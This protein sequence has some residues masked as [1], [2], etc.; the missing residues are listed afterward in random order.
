[1]N[2]MDYWRQR[3]ATWVSYSVLA[4]GIVSAVILFWLVKIEDQIQSTF[5]S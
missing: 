1:M 4:G 2:Y 5:G 3:A